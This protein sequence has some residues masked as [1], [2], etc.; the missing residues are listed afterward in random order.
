MRSIGFAVLALG[1]LL[2]ATAVLASGW[3]EDAKA[4][5][6]AFQ[7]GDPT[8]ARALLDRAYAS[9]QSEYVPAY[10]RAELLAWVGLV[11]RQ[12]SDERDAIAPLEEAAALLPRTHGPQHPQL[13]RVVRHLAQVHSNLWNLP[14]AEERFRQNLEIATATL[15]PSDPE[16]LGAY[17]D[18]A[19]IL[20]K[21]SKLSEGEPY[22]DQALR[23]LAQHH[24]QDER[25]R[26]GLN[27]MRAEI[28]S[29]HG[30]VEE[31]EALCHQAASYYKRSGYGPGIAD[32]H[33]TLGRILASVGRTEEARSQY[34]RALEVLPDVPRY[35]AWRAELRSEYSAVTKNDPE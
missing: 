32:A 24:P 19:H 6:A 35:R 31:A 16:Y 17:S 33:G 2:A 8:N 11:R 12:G 7:A 9:S 22:V 20:V 34:E 3:E 4:G 15:E 29:D 28:L 30:Q 23:L 25:T 10:K 27:L 1:T 13:R 18:M 21:R 26:A 5:V 14:Q